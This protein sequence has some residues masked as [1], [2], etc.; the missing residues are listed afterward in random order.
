[1]P[2][3]IIL[4]A[5]VNHNG[6]LDL[7]RR[8]VDVASDAQATTVKF[9]TFSADYVVTKKAPPANY[10]LN[11]DLF[12]KSQREMLR[13]LEL[14]PSEW[15]YLWRY[16]NKKNINF[17]STA[18]DI[19]SADFLVQLGQRRFKVPSG[20]LTNLPYL[21]HIG[22]YGLP[23][24]VSTGMATMA[25]IE[26]AIELLEQAGTRREDITI[27]HCTT[28]Y[29]TP[30]EE[31][32]LCAMRTIRD[33]FEVQVGYSDHTLG[34]EVPIAAV[35]LGARVIE[36]H[37]TLDRGLPGPDHKASIEPDEIHMMV[38]S[39]RNIEQ[40]LGD[41]KKKPTVSEL[42]NMS[43]VRKSIVSSCAI[44]RGE[45][46]TEGNICVKRPGVGISPIRWNEVVGST[47][48]RDFQEDELIE[49]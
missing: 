6:Q 24:I 30:I 33:A 31:V 23:V 3:E 9:Q 22:R 45:V 40:A 27:L 21:Q 17:L 26:A 29:P 36:K 38:S 28:Q 41:G 12:G 18:F 34:I 37:I 16:C 44:K 5:G 46:F 39:I 49:L 47:A 25:E 32:N 7:A 2:V 35:A 15:R 4:E 19:P 43:S 8:L 10:Q 42:E 14:S 48:S 1:M 11:D 13:D 20:E